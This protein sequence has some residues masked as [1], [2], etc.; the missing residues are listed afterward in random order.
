LFKV[1]VSV[2]DIG[3]LKYSKTENSF[4][5]SVTSTEDYFK[6]YIGRDNSLPSNTYW[7]DVQKSYFS[8][9][10]YTEF[11]DTLYQR[12]LNGQGVVK[13]ESDPGYFTMKLP[14]AMSVQV[15]FKVYRRYFINVTTFT[16]LIQR[17]DDNPHSHYIS[18][19]SLTAR[20]ENRWITVAIPVTY[21]QYDKINFGLGVRTPY[22]YFGVNNLLSAMFKD[23]PSLNIY[24]GIKVSVFNKK[25]HRG[26]DNDIRAF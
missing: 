20:Y 17:Y 18:I 5:M 1:G 10:R 24:F 14:A 23:R 26:V 12:S 15:D 22:F 7:M 19:Y 13:K 16:A 4:N 8:Y 6:R 3:R 9:L 21:N 11:V 2:L 25:T